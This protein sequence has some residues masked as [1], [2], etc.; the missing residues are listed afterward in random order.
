MNLEDI[1]CKILIYDQLAQNIEKI[2]NL[3]Q[4][5]QSN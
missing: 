2:N 4:K 3:K 1:A 5:S